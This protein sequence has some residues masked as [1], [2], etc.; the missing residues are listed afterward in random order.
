MCL[1]R[2]TPGQS[3][4]ARFSLSAVLPGKC[5]SY[6]HLTAGEME[7]QGLVAAA[8]GPRLFRADR[9]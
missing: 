7:A 2:G 6:P 4:S 8:W 3:R 1:L 9:A 5:G